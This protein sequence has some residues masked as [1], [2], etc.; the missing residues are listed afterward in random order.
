[1]RWI[2][3]CI[4]SLLEICSSQHAN[5]LPKTLYDFEDDDIRGL[6]KY[7]DLLAVVLE[8]DIKL[9]KSS[10]VP[11]NALITGSISLEEDFHG[12]NPVLEFKFIK[13]FSLL[14]CTE[15]G[16]SVCNTT[17]H[18]PCIRVP[19]DTFGSSYSQISAAFIDDKI[20]LRTVR[21]NGN[22]SISVFEPRYH[23][24]Q[25]SYEL[26]RYMK[27][28][29]AITDLTVVGAFSTADYTYFI[30]SAKRR[31]IPAMSIV[32]EGVRNNTDI[33][34]TRICNSDKTTNLDSRIDVVLSC[35]GINYGD[36]SKT[37][38]NT[39]TASLYIPKKGKLLVAF[40]HSYLG[41]NPVSMICE[42]DFKEI[43]KKLDY[44][45]S[46]CQSISD[47]DKIKS[48]CKREDNYN[49]MDEKCFL[50]TWHLNTQQPFCRSFNGNPN[51]DNCNLHSNSTSERYGWLENFKAVVGN[52]VYQSS[53][54]EGY[55][56]LQEG[57]NESTLFALNSTNQLL[58][59]NINTK[60][61][62]PLLWIPAVRGR[63]ILEIDSDKQMII[64][65]DPRSLSRVNYVR[66]TCNGLY[67]ECNSIS[68]L[69]PLECAFC[70][71]A[72]G[73]GSVFSMKDKMG[74]GYGDRIIRGV[75]PPQID[76]VSLSDGKYIIEGK[77]LN[78][79]QDGTEKVTICGI[80]CPI[81][82]INSDYFFCQLSY[83]SPGCEVIYSGKLDE[84]Y[85]DFQLKRS[86]DSE[87]GSSTTS[88]SPTSSSMKVWRVIGF[89]VA[90]IL[91]IAFIIGI[92]WCLRHRFPK[93]SDFQK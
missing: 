34:I 42:Y 58:R 93:V 77:L 67:N 4:L 76:H 57:E 44:T 90:F 72:D 75:C 71:H 37:I 27:D 48:K 13:E 49:L 80:D 38:K 64:F 41:R 47:N 85:Q 33:R 83:Q 87:S 6:T 21:E 28:S 35:E 55:I 73:N 30:G 89:I 66:L 53:K 68:W 8:N 39:A 92:Y 79:F 14:I 18:M 69:D 61:S 54:P 51:L 10:S 3:F 88:D 82:K 43:Q 15:A 84:N 86:V 26:V 60:N 63:R 2:L 22:A 19:L 62:E 1:M 23:G 40:E 56:A 17:G 12:T 25:K 5:H 59:L 31:D 91:L 16:C 45:W 9:M 70:A 52:N 32:S 78:N 36:L 74:C 50:Y 65:A 7:G 11:G 46:T 24:N 29:E 20:H 81:E